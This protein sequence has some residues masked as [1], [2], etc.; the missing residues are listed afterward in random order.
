MN[1]LRYE[2]AWWRWLWCAPLGAPE[3]LWDDYSRMKG[4][5][6]AE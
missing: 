2:L 5:R 4:Y 3:P 1:R 6:V